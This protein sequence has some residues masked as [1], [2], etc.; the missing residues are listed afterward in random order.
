[1]YL[2]ISQA[3]SAVGVSISTIRRWEREGKFKSAYRTLG[4][5]RRYALADLR[6]S[7]GVVSGSKTKITLGYARVSSGDQKE[8]LVRQSNRLTEY[9]KQSEHTFEV[10]SDLGSGLN[11]KKRGLKK[12]L[13]LII[14][15]RVG[16]L[17][18]THKDRLLRFGAEIIFYLC[19]FFGTK[20]E[21]IEATKALSDEEVLTRDVLEIITVFSSRLYGKRA[22]RKKVA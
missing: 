10:I 21:I 14:S 5:H 11:Y 13:N 7:V 22:H 4:G 15:G 1:M 3:S 16:K 12:L 19:N 18:M 6:E 8:D 17:V 20:I 2:S 9:C